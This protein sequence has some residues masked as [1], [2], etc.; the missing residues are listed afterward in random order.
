MLFRCGKPVCARYGGLAGTAALGRIEAG[1]EVARGEYYPC[2]LSDLD[3]VLPS[4]VAWLTGPLTAGR[5]ASTTVR[6]VRVGGRTT[7]ARV[8]TVRTYDAG[9]EAARRPERENP[10]PSSHT[11]K[12]VLNPAAI[13]ALRHIED[14]FQKDVSVLLKGMNMEHLLIGEEKEPQ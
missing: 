6:A 3:A 10:D 2:S 1:D 4:N 12:E 5:E 8:R 9:E 11:R 13:Q 14:D 7:A